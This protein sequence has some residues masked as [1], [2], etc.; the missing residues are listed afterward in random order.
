MGKDRADGMLPDYLFI[1]ANTP[2]GN[3]RIG[4]DPFQPGMD[5]FLLFLRER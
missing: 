1:G 5:G 3:D 2:E 4:I